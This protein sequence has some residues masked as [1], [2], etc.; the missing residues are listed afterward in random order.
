ME[1]ISKVRYNIYRNGTAAYVSEMLSGDVRFH[2]QVQQTGNI[3]SLSLI[4][5][6]FIV[7]VL[8]TSLIPA[9]PRDADENLLKLAAALRARYG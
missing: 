3:I 4:M 8:L 2:L 1:K 6:S 9:K 7:A 5:Y